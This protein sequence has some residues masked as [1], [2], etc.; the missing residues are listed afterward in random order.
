M[1]EVHY[2]EIEEVPGLNSE[3]LVLWL[4][5]VAEEEGFTCENIN[6]VFCSDLFLL[7]LN[8]RFLAHDY[9]T[10]IITFDYCNGKILSGELYISVERVKDNAVQLN[11]DFINEAHRVCVH[12]LLH[13]CGYGDKS[14]E[15]QREMRLKEDYYL[16]KYVSRET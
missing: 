16:N 13:L 11:Q 15:D 1:I 14:S 2:N 3:L 12:G 10:D 5:S 6:I 8:K 7:E 4:L 9:F